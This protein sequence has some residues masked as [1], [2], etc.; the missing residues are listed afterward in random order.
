[1]IAIRFAVVAA[2]IFIVCASL[3]WFF[4]HLY[5]I[6]KKQVIKL[7]YS[8]SYAATALHSLPVLSLQYN[9]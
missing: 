9:A 5:H 3:E 7:I 1:M 8:F 6:I 2:V 4:Y